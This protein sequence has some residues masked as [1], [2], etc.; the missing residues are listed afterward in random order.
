MSKIIDLTGQRFGKLLVVKQLPRERDENGKL[1][2]IR[3]LCRC[4]CGNT[5][6]TDGACLRGG[7]GSCGCAMEE[8]N[9]R[10]RQQLV[11]ARE[12]AKK[13]KG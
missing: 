5:C 1:K 9:A 11:A 6:E 13:S 7:K 8:I 12:L 10:K 4:N 3:W 2:P